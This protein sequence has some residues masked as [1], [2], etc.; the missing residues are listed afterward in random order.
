MKDTD[1][2]QLNLW[3]LNIALQIILKNYINPIVYYG[4]F[5]KY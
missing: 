1:I 2:L 4:L 5:S 3:L